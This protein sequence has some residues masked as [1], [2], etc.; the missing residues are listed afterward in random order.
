MTT[1]LLALLSAR[2]LVVVLICSRTSIGIRPHKGYICPTS[3]DRISN[4]ERAKSSGIKTLLLLRPLLPDNII[5]VE[6]PIQ[7]IEKSKNFGL[8]YLYSSNT[9]DRRRCEDIIAKRCET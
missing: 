5:P 4:L 1:T 9:Y 6:E 8:Y 7:L 3:S 2:I